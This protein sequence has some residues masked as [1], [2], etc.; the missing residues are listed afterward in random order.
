[1][2]KETQLSDLCIRLMQEL[3]RLHYTEEYIGKFKT[4]AKEFQSFCSKELGTELFSEKAGEAYLKE[5]YNYVWGDAIS[6]TSHTTQSAI[7]LI[8]VLGELNQY[9]AI[10]AVKK[11]EDISVWAKKDLNIINS[12]I[13]YMQS[14]DNTTKTK[15]S[16]LNRLKNF[17]LFLGFKD[18]ES[19]VDIDE[20][21]LQEYVLSMQGDSLGHSKNRITTLKQ[22]LSFLNKNSMLNKDYSLVLPRIIIPENKNIPYLWDES[23][24]ELLLKSIDRGNPAGKR[25]YA[26]LLLAIQ[27]GMRISDI[28]NLKLED[29]KWESKKIEFI[30][31]KTGEKNILPMLDDVGWALIDYI[32]F[33]RP[34]VESPYVFLYTCA[35][36]SNISASGVG[37]VLTRQLRQCGI[38][39]RIGTDIGMHSFRHALARRLLE[40][41]TQLSEISE[42]LGHKNFCSTSPY[43]KVDIEG[44]RKCALSLKEVSAVD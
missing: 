9:D 38:Q 23:E 41:G 11:K 16:R 8:K 6:A 4:R 40:N 22:Y 1:M 42:I 30:Q 24:I 37:S 15:E 13:I 28:S 34:K 44:M 17:Y 36:Y 25:C 27:L 2:N 19:V 10:L 33:A 14:P 39:K 7:R 43:L 20:K 32:R 31:H 5:K 21:V 26:M 3:K 29:L 35:P 18:L 12:F